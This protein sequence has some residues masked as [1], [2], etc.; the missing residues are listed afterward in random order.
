V[1]SNRYMYDAFISYSSLDST[2]VRN[3]LLPMLE[4]RGFKIIIDFRDF[5]GGAFSIE[6]M[7]RAVL[8]SKRVIIVMT[9]DY[10]RSSWS[11]LENVMAQALDPAAQTRKVLP[12]L[13]DDCTIPLRLRILHWRDLRKGDPAQWE[14]LVQDLI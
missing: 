13:K 5:V 6:E 12:L 11:K 7:E 10:M 1:A 2:W 9:P 3:S 4:S 14:L 8:E